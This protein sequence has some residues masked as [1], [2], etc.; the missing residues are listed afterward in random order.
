MFNVHTIPTSIAAG[1]SNVARSQYFQAVTVA[2]QGAAAS[3][4]S[5]LNTGLVSGCKGRQTSLH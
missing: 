5:P 4:F 2:R 3:L 1:G